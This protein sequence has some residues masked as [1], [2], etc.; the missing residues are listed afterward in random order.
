MAK[1]MEHSVRSQTEIIH[2]P[3]IQQRGHGTNLQAFRCRFCPRVCLRIR[4]ISGILAHLASAHGIRP[5]RDLQGT[6][7][8]QD[9][10]KTETVSV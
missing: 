7:F 2:D 9:T 3:Y 4:G 1:A 5:Y 8:V 6:S 10:T